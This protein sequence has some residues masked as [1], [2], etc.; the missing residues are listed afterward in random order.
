VPLSRH[1]VALA[2][3]ASL[4]SAGCGDSGPEAERPAPKGPVVEGP[5]GRPGDAGV[6]RRWA[7][8]LR[9]GDLRGAARLF[10]VPA[11]VANGEPPRSLTTA[12]QVVAFNASLP[13]GARVVRTRRRG[14]Y[15]VATF[16]LTERP[17]GDCGPGVGDIAATAF[18]LRRGKIVEWLRVPTS[19]EPG[20][21]P[22]GTGTA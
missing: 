21:P 12:D 10:A 19:A 17:G 8:T 4:L 13:C 14:T 6:I 1:A 22:R 20:P 7:D 9:S 3:V 2:L 11:T 16:R 5:P 15:T 18:R